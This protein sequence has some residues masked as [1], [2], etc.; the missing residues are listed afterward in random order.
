MC[1]QRDVKRQ[2]RHVPGLPGSSKQVHQVVIQVPSQF[3]SPHEQTQSELLSVAGCLQETHQDTSFPISPFGGFFTPNS[4]DTRWKGYRVSMGNSMKTGPGVPDWA[5]ASAL[6]TV[7]TI[8]L[9]VRTDAQNLHKGLK[10]DIWSMSCRAP[11]PCPTENT[12]TSDVQLEDRCP[13]G[14]LLNTYPYKSHISCWTQL[15]C[16]LKKIKIK[17]LVLF[18][19]FFFGGGEYFTRSKIK[20]RNFIHKGQLLP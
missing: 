5:A 12:E 17:Q 6:L 14:T 1:G 15:I 16:D 13:G 4:L 11:L 20:K 9:T 2:R 18:Y 8:S 3:K 19:F 10:S 7:G